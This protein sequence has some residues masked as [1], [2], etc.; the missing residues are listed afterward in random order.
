MYTNNFGETIYTQYTTRVSFSNPLSNFL[1]EVVEMSDSEIYHHV[2]FSLSSQSISTCLFTLSSNI[3]LPRDMILIIFRIAHIVC[4][5]DTINRILMKV[6][7]YNY[8]CISTQLII[9]TCPTRLTRERSV[10]VSTDCSL[11]I[12][13]HFS[14]SYKYVRRRESSCSMIF[15]S[16]ITPD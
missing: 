3:S 2:N 10:T 9:V 11:I 4:I 16:C 5:I 15:M 8:S 12:R 13:L 7:L 6:S 1:L 14:R